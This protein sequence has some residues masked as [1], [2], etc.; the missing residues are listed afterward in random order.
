MRVSIYIQNICGNR[1]RNDLNGRVDARLRELTCTSKATATCW[2][3]SLV[4]KANP[5]PATRDPR[6]AV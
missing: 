5:P 2:T 1:F 6:F 4:D 3:A